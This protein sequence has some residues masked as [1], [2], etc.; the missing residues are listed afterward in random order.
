MPHPE[1][2]IAGAGLIGLSLALELERRGVRVTVLER[3]TALKHA[4]IAAGGMLAAHDPENPAPLQPLSDLSV[5]L[6]PEFLERIRQLSGIVVPLHTSR[7]FQSHHGYEHPLSTEEL[8]RLL[9]PLV[10]G[11]HRFMLLEEHSLDPRE[12]A[13]A[14]LA[15]VR[16]TSVRLLEHTELHEIATHANGLRLTTSAGPIETSLLVHARGAWS[17][18]PVA[19]RKGQMMLLALPPSLPLHE[20]IRTPESYI[21]PR[22]VGPNAGRVVIGATV[23]DAGFNTQTHPADLARLR[24]RASA[25][26]PA[27]ADESASPLL[28]HW[29]GLRPATPD[30]L[31]L[32]GPVPGA[33]HQYLA[34]GHYRN[35][36]LLAPATAHVLAQTL[37]NEPAAVDL[38]PFSA[39]RFGQTR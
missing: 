8:H 14:L 13:A 37:V 24:A 31:P 19:P 1:I 17:G 2:T 27:L 29:A 11:D 34:T 39:G 23:E 7:T 30:A 33:P 22:T 3:D 21:I 36:I 4:S 15:A 28:L 12:L 25:L 10:P 18:A 26:L 32:L 5:A 9:P 38:A 16:N 35:G 20:V 6:Y